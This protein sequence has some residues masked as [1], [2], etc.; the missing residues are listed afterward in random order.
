MY[1]YNELYLSGAQR[2]IGSLF[3]RSLS[4]MSASDFTYR[5]LNSHIS[6]AFENGNPNYLAGKSGAELY[7]ELT[8]RDEIED[9][10]L[11]KPSISYWCGMVYCYAQWYFSCSYEKLFSAISIDELSGL[12]HPLHEADI[13]KTINIFRNRFNLESDKIQDL[14]S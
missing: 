13:S 9:V 14:I 1:S 3:E 4:V 5:F 6:K 8:G 10:I 7:I 2:N 12:Y 11:D